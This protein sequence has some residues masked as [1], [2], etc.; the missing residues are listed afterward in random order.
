MPETKNRSTHAD[1]R[2]K[3]IPAAQRKKLSAFIRS[4]SETKFFQPDGNPSMDWNLF[5]A[6]SWTAA[7]GLAWNAAWRAKNGS[8]IDSMQKL[9]AD[10]A[11][12]AITGTPR[13]A[14]LPAVFAE[15]EQAVLDAPAAKS[16]YKDACTDPADPCADINALGYA[17]FDAIGAAKL[18]A[19][20][21]VVEDI[22][23]PGKKQ[24]AEYAARRWEVWQ[25]GYAVRCDVGG[26]MYVYAKNPAGSAI[27]RGLA[28]KDSS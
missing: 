21:V 16:A 22:E 23:F 18:V 1:A 27:T 24:Y 20:L 11:K 3:S 8:D 12:A 13:A 6:E 2:F 19:A 28:R 7:S 10:A 26:T 4:I 15:C 17:D 9:A 25:K 5:R 14:A